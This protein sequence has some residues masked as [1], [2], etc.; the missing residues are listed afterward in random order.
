[1]E[2]TLSETWEYTPRFMG[3]R[4]TSD[5]FSIVFTYLTTAQ[6]NRYARISTENATMEDYQGMVRDSWKEVRGTL[7]VNGKPV[8]TV[9][10]FLSAKGLGPLFSEIAI[11]VVRR[12]NVTEKD[13]GN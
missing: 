12:N 5:P 8:R 3:N 1:M 13:L 10:D 2:I 9:E 6:R 7:A 11:E 4:D